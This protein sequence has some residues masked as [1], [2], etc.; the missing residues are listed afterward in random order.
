MLSRQTIADHEITVN[1]KSLVIFRLDKQLYALPIEPIVQ[2]FE[3]VAI[4]P[5]PWANRAVEGVISV[6]GVIVPVVNVRSQLGLPATR[7]HLHTPILLVKVAERMLGLIVDEVIDVIG[8]PVEKITD[9]AEV[10]PVGLGEVPLLQ[11][12]ARASDGEIILLLDLEHLFHPGQ[13]HGLDQAVK[14]LVEPLVADRGTKEE[15]MLSGVNLG[16]EL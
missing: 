12:M 11:G 8:L 2:I 14:S 6:R 5:I 9:S 3:L 13:A 7:M 4:T 16:A 15:G 1:Q 10:L